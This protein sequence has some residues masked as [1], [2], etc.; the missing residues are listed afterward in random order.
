MTRNIRYARHMRCMGFAQGVIDMLFE[1][2]VKTIEQRSE[3]VFCRMGFRT[4][5]RDFTA[6]YIEGRAAF[7]EAGHALVENPYESALDAA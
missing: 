4:Y 3:A 6:G 2:G 5:L 1:D 7:D